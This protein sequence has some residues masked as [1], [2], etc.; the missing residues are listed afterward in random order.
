M[1]GFAE[2]KDDIPI[3]ARAKRRPMAEGDLDLC[4]RFFDECG[5]ARIEGALVA[6]AGLLAHQFTANVR[7]LENLLLLAMSTSPA[8]VIGLTPPVDVRLQP[9]AKSEELTREAVLAALARVDGN[10]SKAWPLLG[11]SSRDGLKRVM[12][13]Y[14]LRGRG[15]EFGWGSY[16]RHDSRHPERRLERNLRRVRQTIS[17]ISWP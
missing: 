7:E 17:G 12:R 4:S 10:A 3:L 2:R 9:A 1:P 5:E 8:S 13:K 6:G 16:V 14:G 11:L 15:R